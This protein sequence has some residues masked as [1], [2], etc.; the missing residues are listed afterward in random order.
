M[1][2]GQRVW[3]NR[4]GILCDQRREP[5]TRLLRWR[6]DHGECRRGSNS[7]KVYLSLD[8]C[9]RLLGRSNHLSS[10]NVADLRKHKNGYESLVQETRSA[11]QIRVPSVPIIHP[12]P[13]WQGELE[14]R[15]GTPKPLF[16]ES[17]Q[18][19]L[20]TRELVSPS[21]VLDLVLLPQVS[22]NGYYS[23]SPVQNQYG[24]QATIDALVRIGAAWRDNAATGGVELGIGDISLQGGGHF[25]HIRPT[26]RG[27]KPISAP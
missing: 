18:T 17:S 4:S 9:A 8:K 15:T 1:P 24:T 23:Y 13:D 22:G 20:S 11:V 25:R 5:A 12:A 2:D 10:E 3:S 19:V 14:R 27:S 26:R 7:S 21:F 16:V 6:L